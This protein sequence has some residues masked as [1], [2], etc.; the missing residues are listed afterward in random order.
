MASY[1]LG[2]IK[3]ENEKELMIKEY[4]NV[5]SELDSLIKTIENNAK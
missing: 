3:N 5:V 2:F 1:A 4:R